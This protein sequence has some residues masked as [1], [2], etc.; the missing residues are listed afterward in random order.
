MVQLSAPGKVEDAAAS[1]AARI[2]CR[3]YDSGYPGMNQRARTHR[4]RLQRDIERRVRQPLV[5][6]RGSGSAEDEH[7]GVGARIMPRDRRIAR[8]GE[9]LPSLANEYRAHWDL[10]FFGGAASERQRTLHVAR[11]AS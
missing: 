7:F 9:Y 3:V 2:G 8:F 4:A 6:E 5:A 11:I 1:A 10:A